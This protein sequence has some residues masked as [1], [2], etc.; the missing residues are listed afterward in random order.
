[1]DCKEGKIGVL[2]GNGD[3]TFQPAETSPAIGFYMSLAGVEDLNGDGKP[4]VLVS[5]SADQMGSQGMVGVFQGNGDGTYQPPV[6]YS[7][8]ARWIVTVQAADVNG[9]K[10]P[11]AIVSE[12]CGEPSC[13]GV[14]LNAAGPFRATTT[15]SATQLNPS[16]FGQSI[17]FQVGVRSSVGALTGDVAL[18]DGGSILTWGRLV[19]GIA[20][21][22]ISLPAGSHSITAW[23]PISADFG[24]STSPVIDE[25]INPATTQIVLS[26]S[27]NPAAVHQPV[28]YIATIKSQY[29]GAATGYVNFMNSGMQVVDNKAIFTTSYDWPMLGEHSI[30]A[31]YPGDENNIGSTSNEVRQY[32]GNFPVGSK[33]VVTTSATPVFVGQPVTFTANVRSGD[34]RFGSIPD[35]R[36][37]TFID[38]TT[39]L[40]AVPLVGEKA[41]F[42]TSSLGAR[43]HNVRATYAGDPLFRTS[44]ATVA[45]VVQKYATKTARWSSVNPSSFGQAVTFTARVTSEGPEVPT[46]TVVFFDGTTRIGA[47]SLSGGVAKLTK[48]TLAIGIHSIKAHYAGDAFSNTSTSLGLNQV[49]E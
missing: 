2:L 17:T 39:I 8:G 10:K 43:L 16:I 14:M 7:T 11:D 41:L 27:V 18:L 49:V 36:L 9:D 35:G 20:S 29:G 37:V 24:G 5:Y 45:E 44:T 30:I 40:G 32:V 1:L 47:A 13:V 31:L 3:G 22:P 48:S 34:T 28:S 46:G 42:T 19:N 21:M 6:S 25:V 38:G 23:Y 12:P 26:S 4:D 33:T 15:T